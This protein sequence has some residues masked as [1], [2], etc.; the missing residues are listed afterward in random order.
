M[1]R[2]KLAGVPLHA[3]PPPPPQGP[4]HHGVFASLRRSVV[5]RPLLRATSLAWRGSRDAPRRNMR[6]HKLAHSRALRAGG[7]AKPTH[8]TTAKPSVKRPSNAKVRRLSDGR[9]AACERLSVASQFFLCGPSAEQIAGCRDIVRG[10]RG[11]ARAT[12]VQARGAQAMSIASAAGVKLGGGA[13]LG[14]GGSPC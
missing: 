7:G 14:R 8:R 11:L 1:R 10:G 3:P 5:R 9:L 6:S 13:T 12:S 4:T 2:A